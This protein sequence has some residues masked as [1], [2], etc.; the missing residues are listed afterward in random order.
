MR[1]PF[2]VLAAAGT[3]AHHAYEVNAGVGLVFQPFMGLP[4]SIAFWSTNLP[5][6]MWTAARG[7]ERFDKP[8]A[9]AAGTG[10][11]G[12]LVHYSL[13]PWKLRGGVPLLTEAEGLSPAQLPTYNVILLA[14]IAAGV[15]VLLTETPREARRWFAAGVLNGIPLRLSAKHHFAWAAAQARTNP[16]WWNR[17]LQ[18]GD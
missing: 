16:S 5:A 2:H 8:L 10:L 15:L 7:D 12:A 4:G 17:G 3:A 6:L 13:W 11:G 9:F 14:W 18:P 1:R